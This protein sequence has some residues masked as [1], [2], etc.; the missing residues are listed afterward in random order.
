MRPPW[1][2]CSPWCHKRPQ[3]SKLSWQP[4][5]TQSFTA[6]SDQSDSSPC[7][8]RIVFLFLQLLSVS[9]FLLELRKGSYILSRHWFHSCKIILGFI[10][11]IL[12]RWQ[13]GWTLPRKSPGLPHKLKLPRECSDAQWWCHLVALCQ[14]H[15]G[16][17]QD[18]L[19]SAFGKCT[20]Y[21]HRL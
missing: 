17:S 10:S 5:C 13:N 9:I 1:G 4:P 16:R 11:Y 21:F 19:P 6:I 14:F 7:L 2:T 20:R 12:G 15:L 8:G 3:N 18:F